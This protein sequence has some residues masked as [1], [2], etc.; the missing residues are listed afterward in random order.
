MANSV[1]EEFDKNLENEFHSFV[2]YRDNDSWTSERGASKF[3]DNSIKSSSRGVGDE[4]CVLNGM[5]VSANSPADMSVIIKRTEPGK[6]VKDGHCIIRYDSYC[7][8]GWINV[9][10]KLEIAGSSQSLNRISYI[11]AY[12]DRDVEFNKDDKIIESPSVLKFSEIQG[13]ESTS[14]KDPTEQQI[15]NKIGV[16]NP[17]IILARIVVNANTSQITQGLIQDYRQKAILNPELQ[18]DEDDSYVAGF[19]QPNQAK[20]RTRIIVTG[21]NDPTP[22]A[23][24]GIQLIWLRKKA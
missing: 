10:Y 9:D 17:F 4:G 5:Y 14:P 19:V 21:P 8:L 22:A 20:T 16:N 15:R 24:P 12:I 11:V 1:A 3:I 13:T 6:P 23:I 7:Y 18:L 2:S